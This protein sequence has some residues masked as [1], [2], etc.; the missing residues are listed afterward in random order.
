MK[1]KNQSPSGDWGSAS[2]HQ[3][4]IMKLRERSG[5]HYQN[6]K[7]FESAD[8]RRFFARGHSLGLFVRETAV[9]GVLK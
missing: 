4:R 8:S 5:M 9:F 6:C 2:G 3:G 1:Q 7:R